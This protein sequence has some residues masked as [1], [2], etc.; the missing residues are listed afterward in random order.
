M[1]RHRGWDGP[2]FRGRYRSQV[3]NDSDHLTALV[4]YIHLHPVR[5][6]LIKVPQDAP[7]TSCPVYAELSRRPEWLRTDLI[8][9][10]F[11]TPEHLMAETTA[12]RRGDLR[13]PKDFDL[14]RGEFRTW[15]PEIP[16]TEEQRAQR[17][18]VF[19]QPLQR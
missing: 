6:R 9:S 3:V 7:W 1:N 17:R 14:E 4:P 5:A 10:L 2:V 18:K 11:V 16:H 12:L 15:S 13:W 8:L 19:L